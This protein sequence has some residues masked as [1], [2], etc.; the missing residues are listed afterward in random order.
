MDNTEP[1]TTQLERQ[2]KWR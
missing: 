2:K 1:L